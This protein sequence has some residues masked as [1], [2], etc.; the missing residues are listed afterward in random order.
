MMPLA[1]ILSVS[2]IRLL[3][4]IGILLALL[5]GCSNNSNQNSEGGAKE[6]RS[7][8]DAVNAFIGAIRADD[9]PR[10]L[11]I[12]GPEG[13]DIVSSGD[14]VSDRLRRQKFIQLYDEKH[15]LSNEN[16]D[17]VTLVVGKSDWPFPVQIVRRGS[18]WVFDSNAGREEIINRR[19]GENEL[20]AIETC[21]A[22]GDAQRDF[23]LQA[24][25]ADGIAHYA[26]QFAS[27][28]GKH[29]GLYWPTAEGE[30]PSP[31]G[32]LVVQAAAEGYKR[33]EEGPTPYHGYCFRILEAQGAHAPDGA[34]DYVVND[35]MILGFALVA[36]PA[37]YGN[38]GIMTF[39]MG[40]DGVVYQ[41]NLGEKTQELATSMKAFDP[42]EGWGKAE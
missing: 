14:D 26:R 41:K 12:M 29:N 13:E 4:F 8:D 16:G 40:P 7:A 19:I 6:F 35:K 15:S 37:D 23:A 28:P 3:P 11:A 31:L 21:K 18:G 25:S 10:L 1:N 24:R 5:T 20:A 36:Y 32:E 22:I 30:E 2:R 27:D 38:S 17:G 39:T 42:G 9:T 33:R 34:V